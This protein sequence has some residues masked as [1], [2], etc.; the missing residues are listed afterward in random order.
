MTS[1]YRAEDRWMTDESDAIVVRWGDEHVSTFPFTYLRGYCPCAACQGHGGGPA[2]WQGPPADLGLRGIRLV[3]AYGINPEWSDG[4]DTGIF[5]DRKLR[6]MCPCPECLDLSEP[7][8]EL[9]LMPE[10]DG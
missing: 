1:K 8:A 10:G 4:H 9:R 2:T 7:G 5:A 3:G 6:R